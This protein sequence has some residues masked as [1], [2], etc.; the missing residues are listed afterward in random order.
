MDD[1]KHSQGVTTNPEDVGAG[2]GSTPLGKAGQDSRTWGTHDSQKNK[3]DKHDDQKSGQKSGEPGKEDRSK[4]AD[5]GEGNG[6]DSGKKPGDGHQ[7]QKT[8][9]VS[10]KH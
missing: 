1:K 3:G 9:H 10:G 2:G 8:P 5:L 7:G 4:R 6:Q